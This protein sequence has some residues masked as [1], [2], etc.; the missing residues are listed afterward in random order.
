MLVLVQV[1]VLV[2]V[3]VLML[4]LVLVLMLVLATTGLKMLTTTTITTT[5]TYQRQT[6]CEQESAKRLVCWL[7]ITG[8]RAL[9]LSP[10]PGARTHQQIA[11]VM[12]TV[13]R[14]SARSKLREQLKFTAC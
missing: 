10:I 13:P 7:H 14:L 8:T 9:S 12:A 2:L 6:G 11:M 4:M 1:L 3:L 5:T